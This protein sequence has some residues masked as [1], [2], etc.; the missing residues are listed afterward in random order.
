MLEQKIP[1]CSPARHPV[2]LSRLVPFVLSLSIVAGGGIAG[3]ATS[4]PASPAGMAP[5]D[6]RVQRPHPHSIRVEV[7]GGRA[8]DP[9]GPSQISNRALT[10]SIVD[11]IKASRVFTRVVAGAGAEYLLRVDIVEL[12]QSPR[13]GFSM[14]ARME[15]RWTLLRPDTGKP[16]WAETIHSSYTA[17]AISSRKAVTRMRLATEGAAKENIRQ[18]IE[19]ISRMELR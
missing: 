1:G 16:V 6:L 3:C 9:K 17:S 14:T 5:Q 10:R 19:R 11:S 18:G 13:T 4:S 15:A 12:E 2:A 7:R 8:T